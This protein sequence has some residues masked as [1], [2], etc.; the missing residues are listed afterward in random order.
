LLLLALALDGPETCSLS[1]TVVDSVTGKG[2]S[3]V[4]LLLEPAGGPQHVATA[5]TDA[6][7]RFSMVELAPGRYRLNATRSG[8]LDGAYGSRGYGIR[9]TVL[10]LEAGQRLRIEHKLVAA[11]VIAGMVRDADGE[12]LEGIH[13]NIGRRTSEYGRPRVEGYNSTD[14]DDEGRYRIGKLPP[15]KY[16]VAAEPPSRGWNRVDHSPAAAARESAMV[17]TFYPGAPEM[18]GATALTVRPGERL[19]GIDIAVLHR[20]VYRVVGRVLNAPER[21]PIVLESLGDAGMRDFPVRTTAR[22]AA[23]DFELRGIPAGEYLLKAGPAVA[24]VT[25]AGDVEGLRV[26]HRPGAEIR[27]RIVVEGDKAVTPRVHVFIT[28]DGRMGDMPDVRPDLT[29]ISRQLSP[30]RHEVRVHEAEPRQYFLKSI[31]AGETDVLSEGLTAAG[32]IVPLEIVLSPDGAVV[33][34]VVQDAESRPL[35]GA[36]VVLVPL[37]GLRGRRD[38]YRTA[39]TDPF[40]RYTLD[41][42]APGDYQLFAWE[43]IDDGAWNDPEFLKEYEK[44][45]EPVTVGAKERKTVQLQALGSK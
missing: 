38:L 34:G 25:V 37:E 23:G 1:G 13:I 42:A 22:N 9:G 8:Y 27:G 2:L 10:E 3:K 40:G 19:E 35:L 11:G 18:A 43:E 31:R 16:F 33:Q 21:L 14:T 20:R 30:L 4:S 45:G 39:N 24:P 7:G 36:T 26:E 29:F 6:E 41:P 5:E 44:R 12:P 28:T 15:G 32:G 17:L